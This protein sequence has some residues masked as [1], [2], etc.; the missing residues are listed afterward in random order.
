M[1]TPEATEQARTNWNNFAA[2]Y[3]REPGRR[4]PTVL[5]HLLDEHWGAPTLPSSASLILDVACGPGRTTAALRRM[6][7]DAT[8]VL[9][10]DLSDAMIDAAIGEGHVGCTFARAP[11][12]AM[13]VEDAEAS[14]VLCNLGLM[15]FPDAGAALREFNRVL[16]PGGSVRATLWGRPERTTS[17]TL[18][19]DVARALG[20]DIPSPPR[21]NFY[22]GTA[23]AL[24]T[25]TVSTGLRLV[26]WRY[27]PLRWPFPTDDAALRS[28]GLHPEEPG[29]TRTAV[30]GLG[31]EALR[32]FDDAVQ[33]ELRR[34]LDAGGGE[35]VHDLLHA[36]W[37][38]A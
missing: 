3:N 6:F 24:D 34:R 27:V 26:A 4:T 36:A 10:T 2:F 29:A 17:M 13:P 32:R 9:G 38:K 37:Q 21:S 22:L 14:F 25:V 19:T 23:E 5:E 8:R 1:S 16:A 15:L 12:D 33:V 18:A 35:L 28:L 20:L 30:A 7:P 31:A 11:A